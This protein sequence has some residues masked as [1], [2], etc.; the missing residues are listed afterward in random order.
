M[1]GDLSVSLQMKTYLEKH[2]KLSQQEEVRQDVSRKSEN[3]FVIEK[4]YTINVSP[5]PL[6]CPGSVESVRL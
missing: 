5:V 2:G 1:S 3:V 4:T 6:A